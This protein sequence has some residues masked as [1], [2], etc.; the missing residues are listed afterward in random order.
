M[1]SIVCL[2]AACAA[3]IFSVTSQ[4]QNAPGGAAPAYPTRQV[5]IIVPYPAGGP[6]DVMARLIAQHLS[7]SLGQSFFVENLHR[8]QFA[9]RRT[10]HPVRDQ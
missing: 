3:L 1:K 6:T 10:Y 5:R 2:A 4:A 9:G 8:G 7:E